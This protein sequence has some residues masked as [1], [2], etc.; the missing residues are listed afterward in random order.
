ML[1]GETVE[2]PKILKTF[3]VLLEVPDD[4]L[5]HCLFE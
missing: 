3:T 5:F 2:E 1:P 4:D